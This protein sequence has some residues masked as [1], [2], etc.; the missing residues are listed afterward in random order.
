MLLGHGKLG[1]PVGKVRGSFWSWQGRDASASQSWAE[2]VAQPVRNGEEKEAGRLL[3]SSG[4]EN[5]GGNSKKGKELDVN[6]SV[7]DA[8]PTALWLFL[9][10]NQPLAVPSYLP[11]AALCPL[12]WAGVWCE[13]ITFRAW[14]VSFPEMGEDSRGL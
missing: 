14:K 7:P 12:K 9:S 8:N 10:R 3:P 13:S 2:S 4:L 5:T 1:N 11:P 6:D